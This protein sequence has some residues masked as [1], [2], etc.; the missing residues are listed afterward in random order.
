MFVLICFLSILFIPSITEA[1]G[2]L[3]HV[4]LGYQVLDLGSAVI[5]ASIY[6]L[7]KKYKNDFLYGNLSAD[8]LLGKK[9]QIYEK[10][11]HNWDT[12][13]ELF[14]SAKT[15]QQKAFVYGYLTHLSADTVVHN[16]RESNLPF[17]QLEKKFP[18]HFLTRFTHPIL[19]IKS[20]SIVNKKHRRVLKGL[21]KV[22]QKRNDTLLENMLESVFFSFK[23]NKR[24]FNGFLLLSKLHNYSSLSNFINKHL[25]Y[26]I[27]VVD[28]Y[29]FQQES[30][31]RMFELL[32]NGKNSEVLKKNP[33]NRNSFRKRY[34]DGG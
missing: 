14:K 2:P 28:I 18:S 8:I 34:Y 12:A 29:R 16:L 30:L 24:I 4:Y 33:L 31:N 11:S 20:D 10:N 21:D 6:S 32:K 13:W 23:T 7:L 1:W 15:D 27:P 9:F 19:E 3:T 5:P 25:P 22:M 17:I 26:E